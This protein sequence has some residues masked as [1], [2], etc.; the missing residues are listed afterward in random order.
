M[1]IDKD[2]WDREQFYDEVCGELLRR[3]LKFDSN[4]LFD[5][6]IDRW[7]TA[8]TAS[9]VADELVASLPERFTPQPVPA[10]FYV[11]T[12]ARYVLVEAENDAQARERGQ[13]ALEKLYADLGLRHAV[14]I[15]TVRPAT[16]DEI[17][18]CRWGEEAL[19]REG[20]GRGV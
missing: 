19:A 16:P 17:E 1:M 20:M 9:A 18:F 3:N 5:L 12:L 10:T 15:L 8:K 4:A 6:I 11:A 13:P 14:E 7:P 2:Y